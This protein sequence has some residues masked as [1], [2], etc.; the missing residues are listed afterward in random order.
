MTSRRHLSLSS[1]FLIK[2]EPNIKIN[3]SIYIYWLPKLHSCKI[4]RENLYHDSGGEP[5]TPELAKRPAR[6]CCTILDG[7]R[8][9]TSVMNWYWCWGILSTVLISHL[10]HM[11]YRQKLQGYRFC[12]PRFLWNKTVYTFLLRRTVSFMFLSWD[13]NL[14]A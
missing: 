10:T 5:G 13:I 4:L 1:F 8:R 6:N 14:S 11:Q 12:S 7:K 3:V 2:N 9:E